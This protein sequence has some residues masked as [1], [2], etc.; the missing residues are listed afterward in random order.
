MR[1]SHTVSYGVRALT[2]LAAAGDSNP[3]PCRELAR[4]A[5]LPERFLL[6]ILRSLVNHGLLV[7]T[8]GV[9]G[10]YTLARPATQITLLDV[11]EAIDGDVTLELAGSGTVNPMLTSAVEDAT[12]RVREELRKLHFGLFAGPGVSGGKVASE[13]RCAAPAIC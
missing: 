8:R 6:Q 2:A 10:G 9:E 13:Q 3:V 7:S 4:M 1:L 12:E 5:D 11:I